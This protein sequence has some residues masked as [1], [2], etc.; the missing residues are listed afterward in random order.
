MIEE[1]YKL[2][3]TNRRASDEKTA[4]ADALLK[5]IEAMKD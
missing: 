3:H 2:S 4:E 5:R 1:A